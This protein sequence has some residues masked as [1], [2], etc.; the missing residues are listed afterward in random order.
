MG[1][2]MREIMADQDYE[3]GTMDVSDQQSTFNGVMKFSGYWGMPFSIA[4]SVFFTVLL[5]KAGIPAAI[6]AAILSFIFT[7]I[8]VKTFFA[9]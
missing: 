9:H 7:Q 3:R 2:M 1:A 5:V 4:F 6:F 8:G